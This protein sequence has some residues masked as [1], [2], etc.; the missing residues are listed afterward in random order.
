[1]A[2]AHED[3]IATDI[4][5]YLEAHERKSLLRF[6]TCGS[7]DD[8]KSTLIGRLLYESQLV[9]EDHLIALEADS[10]RVGTQGGDLDFALLVDG[11]AAER[12][13]GI[14][15]D[16]AYRFFSTEKR[17]FIV[18]D[19]PGHEQYTR[20]MV[21]GASTTDLAVILIDARKGVLTQT[22]RHSFLVS[23][24]GIRQVVVA[25]NK[26]DL[27]DYSQEVFDQI[28]S[29]YRAFAAEIGLTQI[30]C[31]P[32]SALRGDNITE[33]STK[34]PWYHGPT[35]LGY[36][37]TVDVEEEARDRPFRMP[38]QWVNRPDHDFRGYSGTIVGGTIRTGQP[39]RVLP[40]GRRSRIA[41]ITT[42]DGDLE[43]AVV[44]QAVTLVLE[45]EI[46]VSRGD[47]L[48]EEDRAPQVADQFEAHVIWMH[49]REM[50]P[51]RPYLMK[52]GSMTVGL[53]LSRPKFK[54]NV[55]TMEH[56]AATTLALN[57]IGVCSLRL[58]QPVPFDSYRENRDMGGFIII[59]RLTN[60]TLG[61][62]LL[63]FALRRADSVQWQ[64][65]DVNKAARAV[66]NGHGPCAIWF[67]GLSGSGKS[68]I[69]NLVEKRLDAMGAHTY[70][71][72][73]DNVR[74]GLSRDLGFTPA[75]RVENIRRVA[76]VTKLM[77]DAGLL[78]LVSFIS[79]FVAERRFARELLQVGEF[80]EVFVD[81][82]LE[83]A[84][85]RDPKGLYRKARRGELANFTGVD[86]P[87]EV[88]ENPEIR[89]DTANVSAEDAA[90]QV[91]AQLRA[92]GVLT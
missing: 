45:D 73:G 60:A 55:N 2:L 5:A 51:G 86:S 11:L 69:S 58:D 27:V 30:V 10:R 20:N 53:T 75:D 36:L 78:V 44:G 56:L 1:M 61:A 40:S 76:E 49:E 89:I 88:P 43:E 72:D 66:R 63:H 23:L 16:V 59:D 7:V 50:L 35:L 34:T 42:F 83:L 3:L 84:E 48:C 26:L 39:V 80:C 37:E 74:L 12:E 13:Q 77:V 9:F 22:R 29:D 92:M 33:A 8:G 47:V 65:M 62:G 82:S 68:T 79:P 91:V 54:V 90:D 4:E 17:K 41:R 19:T 18:A 81:A 46:D 6:I 64:S 70:L 57:E 85:A 87:Y 21:T 28:E 71:L 24:L 52:I 32:V 15:I 67:T 25:V 31:I 14:T 38:V